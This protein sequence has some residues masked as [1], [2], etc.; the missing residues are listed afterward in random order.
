MENNVLRTYKF[1]DEVGR[2]LSIFATPTID[3]NLNIFALTCSKQDNFCKKFARDVYDG[4]MTGE[5][6]PDSNLV[7]PYTETIPVL[8]GK[9]KSTFIKYCK[10]NFYRKTYEPLKPQF[11]TVFIKQNVFNI[12]RTAVILNAEII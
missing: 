10:L 7:H 2:R 3:D 12:D 5:F 1:Y 6:K 4:C 8:E 9:P 11:K